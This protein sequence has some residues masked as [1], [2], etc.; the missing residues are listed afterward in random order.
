MRNENDVLEVTAIFT[1]NPDGQSWS[2]P[3]DVGASDQPPH[4]APPDATVAAA[5]NVPYEVSPE[6]KQ[7][8]LAAARGQQLV[9]RLAALQ[10]DAVQKYTGISRSELGLR[11]WNAPMAAVAS[12][13][14]LKKHVLMRICKL[15]E[16]PTPPKGYF[17]MS[18]ANRPI[19]WTRVAVGG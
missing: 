17:N 1:R 9:D 14:G 8:M 18:F 12:R 10:N 6:I 13:L 11:V 4:P 16:V 15:Y 19:R 5:H 3:E 7:A 2:P